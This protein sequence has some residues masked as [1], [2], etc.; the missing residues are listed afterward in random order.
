MP[1]FKWQNIWSKLWKSFEYCSQN[2]VLA[3]NNFSSIRTNNLH[4]RS[5]WYVSHTLE[6]TDSSNG[7]GSA[8]SWYIETVSFDLIGWCGLV[9]WKRT[10][11]SHQQTEPYQHS[12]HITDVFGSWA[13]ETS[14]EYKIEIVFRAQIANLSHIQPRRTL[15]F[16]C[17]SVFGHLE[18]NIHSLSALF[19]LA[20][21]GEYLEYLASER[22]P[23]F[24]SYRSRAGDERTNQ[25]GSSALRHV[26]TR[27]ALRSRG[28]AAD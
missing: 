12:E 22:S 27:E 6:T 2:W 21:W 14:R 19:L 10:R 11:L 7:L 3:L 25:N 16:I 5:D 24:T 8:L 23:V 18:S 9:K 17:K 15:L 20:A 13:A 4:L 26:E 1:P 28:T